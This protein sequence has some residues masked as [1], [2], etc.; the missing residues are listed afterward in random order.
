ML[1]WLEATFGSLRVRSF[2]IL[3]FGTILSFVAFF[4]STVVQSVVAF[5][6]V[7]AN[8]AVG[9][10]VFGQGIAMAALGPLGGA[11]ADR[12]PKRRMV[13]MGQLAASAVFATLAVLMATDSMHIAWLAL[14]SLL[15]GAT[16]AFLGPAR[17]ALVVDLVP[18]AQRGNAMAINAMA[19]TGSRVFGPALAG[20]LLGWKTSGAVGAFATM[21]VF[22][23]VS[24]TLVGWLPRSRVRAG[25]T[26][27][28]VFADVADGLRY[29]R[30]HPRLLLLIGFFVSVI[31]LGFPHV[32]V[33]PGYIVNGFGRAPSD[34]SQ[35]Y[36][37]SA[38]GALL[39]SVMVARY[40]DSP[41]ATSIYSALAVGFGLSLIAVALAPTF[42]L[43]GLGMVAVGAA[44]G[45]FQSLTGAVIAREAEARY[46]GRVMS[47]TLVAFGAFGLMALPTGLLADAVGER[48]T[49]ATLGCVLTLWSVLM[50][51]QATRKSK[52]TVFE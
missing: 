35:L 17:Q 15:I 25:A 44:S 27:H 43:A 8:S 13:A 36:L 33:L 37:A 12:W 40:A 23:G 2:R 39:A 26:D 19:N 34:V 31:L 32:T 30:Y 48:P 9:W 51:A 14:G 10:V 1:A 18:E 7:G 24:A 42:E 11:L 16:F 6:L 41:S 45:G 22:Y 29:I 3:W 21:S 38:V 50:W 20:A 49:L 47:I 52:R 46:I 4:M 5:E 28:H